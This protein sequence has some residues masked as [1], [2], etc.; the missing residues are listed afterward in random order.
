[1]FRLPSSIALSASIVGFLG[2]TDPPLEPSSPVVG[3]NRVASGASGLNAPGGATATGIPETRIDVAW[4]DKSSNETGFEVHRSTTGAG[5][6]FTLLATTSA[7]VSHYSDQALQLGTYFCYKIRAVRTSGGKTATSDFSNTACAITPPAAPSSLNAVGTSWPRIDLSWTDNASIETGF[8]ILRSKDGEN[9][10]FDVAYWASANQLQ[11]ADLQVVP[12]VRYCYRIEA[13]REYSPPDGGTS[14]AF[15]YSSPS[16]TACAVPPLP[17]E[18]PPA[19]Y[20][21]SAKP[22]SSG[23]IAVTIRWTDASMPPPSFRAYRSTDGG[24]VWSPIDLAG[25]EN[26]EFADAPVPSEQPLCYRVVAYN[27]AGDAAPSSPACTAAPAAP[28]NL[29]ATVLDPQTLELS[30]LLPPGIGSTRRG[31]VGGGG[32]GRLAWRQHDDLPRRA[33]RRQR[34]LRPSDNDLVLCG[35]EEGRRQVRLVQRGQ[36]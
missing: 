6:A 1:M 9:G 24:V 28:T 8:R 30:L 27:A 25:G 23:S 16:N 36:R 4:G 7:N 17:T 29:V 18:P 19:A 22:T 5:G 35:R 3:Q 2:C 34:Q 31:H 21:V 14:H 15:V 10:T 33:L 12:G 20:A 11:A 26:G 13:V 32:G